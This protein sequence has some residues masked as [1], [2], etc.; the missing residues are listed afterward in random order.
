MKPDSHLTR[1]AGPD[2]NPSTDAFDPALDAGLA[3]AFGPDLT[4]GGWSHPP[5]LRDDPSDHSPVVRPSSAEM[6]R[7][8]SERYQL[9]GEIARGGM[10]VILKG[11]DPD[12]GR[13]L[14]FKVLKS[15]LA[16]RPAAVQRFVEEA[17]VG[18]QLQHPGVVPVYDLGRFPDGRPYFAMKLVKGRT[19]AERLTGRPD[20]SAERGE[21]L[22]IFLQICQTVAYAHAKGVIHRDLK[23]SNVM[24][25]DYGEVLVVDWG[26]AKV[27]PRG[28]IADEEKARRERPRPEHEEPTVIR[29]AR[30]GS[31]A[32][33]D[34]QPGSVL[35][36]PAFMSPEQAAGEIDKLDE[37]ADV[38]GLG[39]VLCVVLTGQ[40]PYRA[41]SAEAVRLK[42]VRG[43]LTDAF[44]RLDACGT[45]AELVGTCKRCLSAERDARPRNAGEV[46]AEVTAYLAA[47]EQRAH[48]AEL[49]RAAAAA[50]AKEQ[51][52]RRR[53]QLALGAALGL[54]LLGGGAFGWWQDRQA[55]LAKRQRAEFATEQARV[56]G[57]RKAEQVRIDGERK[58]AEA[59]AV[60]GVEAAIRLAVDLRLKYRFAEAKSALEQAAGLIPAEGSAELSER[61][62]AASAD[63]AFVVELDA[64][65]LRRSTW[66]PD[67][68]RKGGFDRAGVG[69]AYRRA[70]E[71]RGL[72]VAAEEVNAVAE[73]IRASAVKADI[74]AALDDWAAFEQDP[75]IVERVLAVVRK[76]DPGPWLDLFRDPGV[77]ASRPAVGL[78]ASSADTTRLAPGTVTALSVLMQKHDLDPTRVLLAAQFAHP[79]D[80]LIAFAL[81]EYYGNIKDAAQTI[82]HFRTAR[83]LRPDN[84][85]ILNDLGVFLAQLGD[86]DGAIACYREAIRLEPTFSYPHSNLGGVLLAKE[87]L[88]EAIAA[89]REA[90][91]LDPKYADAHYNLGNALVA[92]GQLDAA[93]VAFR[94]ASKHDPKH[95]DAHY[96]LGV[97]LVAKGQLDAAIVAFRDAIRLNPGYAQAH[98][99][100]G[101]ALVVKGQLDAAIAAYRE[102]I[103][104]DPKNAGAHYNLGI[105][106]VAKGQ[107][108]AA[109]AA[110]REAIKLDPKNAGAHYNLGIAL[111]AKGQLDA[112]IVAYRDAIR[113]NPGLAEAHCNL[114]HRLRDRGELFEAAAMLRKGHE[115][116]RQRPGW[117]YPSAK[118]VAECE[119]E[120][121]DKGLI[122]P[123]PREVKR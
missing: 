19:L 100:L 31:A 121:A 20:P 61:L 51:R 73:R 117:R 104:H 17:Q 93:I 18:G 30:S 92:K 112:G 94:E 50:E 102:A 57:E 66:V 109:I 84:L 83:A 21:F 105:A 3:A 115:L 110:S 90:I 13:D 1:S 59:R 6:S 76:A 23:P 5:L 8:G 98:S 34:T 54:L 120:M 63:L 47:V 70:F 10:G 11:R 24:V 40:P 86:R 33:S 116:G 15:E 42:A 64:A 9:L 87:Q 27:L 38:F 4:P 118:W 62:L 97:A 65:R 78:L 60:V 29:T 53:V 14:A 39:A 26:L 71:S 89:Y 81:G 106:L 99:N 123:A 16:S 55:E 32:G 85:A 25:G 119:Q 49:D 52:K 111:V 37:R 22:Q 91:K 69:P 82:A 75:E 56:D 67:P 48:R 114:G 103:K 79:G 7:G 96:N 2:A 12:L 108:D 122:A 72:D 45:D 28:G 101:N 113:L 77:R 95:A 36:T 46:A 88:D 58:A 68:K 44:A 74:V 41:D 35:G 80:F 107:L 43:Q